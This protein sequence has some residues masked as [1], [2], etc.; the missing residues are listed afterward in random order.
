MPEFPVSAKLNISVGERSIE[1]LVDLVVDTFSPASEISGALGDVVRLG[2]IEMASHITK[3]AKSIAE[4]NNLEMIAPPLKF[5][6]QFYEKAS[7]ETESEVKLVD[8]WS[9]LLCNVSTGNVDPNL[10]YV[11]LVSKMNG[12]SAKMFEDICTKVELGVAD[13]ALL[14]VAKISDAVL[15]M[16]ELGLNS[17]KYEAGLFLAAGAFPYFAV[18]SKFQ[19][20][21]EYPSIYEIM[22]DESLRKKFRSVKPKLPKSDTVKINSGIEFDENSDRLLAELV[23]LGLLKEFSYDRDVFDAE[24]GHLIVRHNLSG[25]VVTPLGAS[26]YEATNGVV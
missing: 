9:E 11:D 7:V 10:I 23:V 2:R 14:Q 4:K 12:E 26:F 17:F 18:S 5:L 13:T 15:E 19:D 6:A 16:F 20:N 22:A 1:K 8:M 21:P 24:S 25:F 3:R